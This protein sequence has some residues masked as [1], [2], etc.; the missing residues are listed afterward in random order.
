[1][2]IEPDV[3]LLSDNLHPRDPEIPP[4]HARRTLDQSYYWK[5]ENT[6]RRDEDQVVNRGTQAG[7]SIYRTSRLVM[8]DQLWLY[9]LDDSK[10]STFQLGF[11]SVSCTLIYALS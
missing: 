5:L 6:D 9:I 11:A 3:R 8:V 7:N 4:L 2:D 10:R 1:M